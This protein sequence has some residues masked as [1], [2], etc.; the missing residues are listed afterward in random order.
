MIDVKYNIKWNKSTQ[1]L[2]KT[3]PKKMMY[4]TARQFLDYVIP[5]IPR[6]TGKMRLS[7]LQYAVKTVENGYRIASPTS[8][9]TDVYN[10]D[11]STTNWTT[12]NT[13]SQWFEREWQKKGSTIMLNS[14][15]RNKI[16]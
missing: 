7:T 1:N 16:K 2:L 14:I 10:M 12:P 6:D 8:Y 4:S 13:E 9:A 11:N 3:T 5:F 15:A